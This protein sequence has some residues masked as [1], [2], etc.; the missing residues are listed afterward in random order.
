[1]KRTRSLSAA[2]AVTALAAVLAGCSGGGQG[3][4]VPGG[5]TPPSTGQPEQPGQAPHDQA[6]VTFASGMIPHHQ[7]AVEMSRAAVDRAR[8]QEVRDL[9]ERIRAAQG[10]EIQELSGWLRSWGVEVPSGSAMPGM[11][12]GEHGDGMM[13]PAE[14]E[15]LE[16]SSGAEFD[17]AFLTMMIEHHEGAVAMARTELSNGRF[18]EAKRLA[19]RIIDTQQ[20][21]I[22]T[23]RRLLATG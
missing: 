1:M 11:D 5:A 8:S 2:V 15:Q 10:P 18:P 3:A 21:E 16:R 20:A 14:M 19:Q 12:H 17:E 4:E 13:S 7:Q 6:D 9:A 22:D 23:M